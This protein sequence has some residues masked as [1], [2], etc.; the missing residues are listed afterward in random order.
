MS[1]PFD[2]KK[3]AIIESSVDGTLCRIRLVQNL[4][5]A[6]TTSRPTLMGGAPDTIYWLRDLATSGDTDGLPHLAAAARE[7]LEGLR[8]RGHQGRDRSIYRGAPRAPH[9]GL[10]RCWRP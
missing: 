4:R 3:L 5:R 10:A 7:A 8:K 1:D 2:A 9:G 6:L